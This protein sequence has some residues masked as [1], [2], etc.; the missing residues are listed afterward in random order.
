MEVCLGVPAHFTLKS[1]RS[2][3]ELVM[4]KLSISLYIC[5]KSRGKREGFVRLTRRE[6]GQKLI[7]V[8]GEESVPEVHQTEAGAYQQHG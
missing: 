6:D 3:L 4:K 1:M 2:E 7:D 5:E 8:H